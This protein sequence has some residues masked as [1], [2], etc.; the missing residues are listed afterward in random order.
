MSLH[1][2]VELIK[3]PPP[4]L[5]FGGLTEPEIEALVGRAAQKV[6]DN[7]YMEIGKTVAQKILW[8]IGIATVAVLVYLAGTGKLKV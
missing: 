4:R 1:P 7:F 8:V 3:E 2:V 5:P 6:M